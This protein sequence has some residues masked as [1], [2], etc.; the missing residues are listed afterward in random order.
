M[1]RKLIVAAAL[2]AMSGLAAFWFLTEP[3]TVPASALGPH[4]PNLANG[5]EMFYAGGCASCHAVP[6]Q[7]D[8]TKLGGGL[9]LGSP[10]GTFYVPNISSDAKDGIGGWSEAQFVTAM[11][12]GTSP[13]GRAS[14]SRVSLHVISAYE[15]DD[16]RD[17]FAYLKTLPAMSGKVRDH[18]SAISHS[19][20]AE[21]LAAG[22][23]CFSTA[24]RS[25]PIP[26]NRRNGIVAP[27]W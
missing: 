8:K 1:L 17:L 13:G 24:R 3:E 21:R 4:T 26:R 10:F 27:I 25:H 19:I 18:D 22:S 16:L 2:A 23:C 6:K 20:F 9:A 5:K 12:K 15:L 11:V 7:E 14:F